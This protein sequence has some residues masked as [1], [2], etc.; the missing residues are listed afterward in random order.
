MIVE[1]HKVEQHCIT[2]NAK[3]RGDVRGNPI[4]EMLSQSA[5]SV[6][7]KPPIGKENPIKELLSLRVMS[8]DQKPRADK[9][10]PIKEGLSQ[11]VLSL[12]QG[13]EKQSKIDC[14]PSIHKM[15]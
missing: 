1:L 14:Q 4:K 2:G 8:L 11:S 12:D 7:Q 9:G 3:E 15:H 5:M 10:D 13:L 6:D